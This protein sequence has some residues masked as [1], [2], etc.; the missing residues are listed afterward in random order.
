MN[1]IAESVGRV[2]M[3]AVS[4]MTTRR[5]KDSDIRKW[6]ETEYKGDPYAY[7]CLMHNIKPD[8]RHF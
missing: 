6:V 2:L 1:H 7:Y 4:S 8:P 3:T 5:P